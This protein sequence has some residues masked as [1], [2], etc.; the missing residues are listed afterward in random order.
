[1]KILVVGGGMQGKVIAENLLARSEKPQVTIADVRQ[2]AQ[3]AAG[4][5]FVKADV[6]DE[7]QVKDAASAADAAVL[8]VPSSIAHQALSNLIATGIPIADVSFTPNP[9][10]DLDAKAKKSGACSV[11]D[12]G[13][14]PGLSHLL[15]GKAYADLGGL[16]SA[17]IYV[18]GMPQSPPA[19]FRHAVY[20]NPHD[21][22]DEYFRP[23]RSRQ[24]GKDMQPHP[25]D[26]PFEKF[27]DSELGELDAFLSD[28]S[29]SLLTSFPDVKNISEWTLRWTGHLETMSNL[30]ALGLLD[31]GAGFQGLGTTLGGKFP[32]EKYPDV[33]LMVVECSRGQEKRRWRLIDRR[34]NNQSAM[35]RTTGYTTAA[36]A[37]VLARGQFKEP[38]VHPPERLGALE[39][40]T[41]TIIEDLVARGVKI[42]QTA[43]KREANLA[44]AGDK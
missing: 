44:A 5:N 9:P 31:E 34:T 40:V 25:L 18:G 4:A 17:K 8:A 12:C 43:G 19:V 37:M 22:L 16:D 6:L 33:L 21:L 24:N 41:K 1:M 28:G 29:R 7:K 27:M 20:F 30:R 2:P 42:E 32:A 35:S 13:V 14:A 26:V 38:G 10:L 36:V 11:V 15:V 39:S 23:A 3:L